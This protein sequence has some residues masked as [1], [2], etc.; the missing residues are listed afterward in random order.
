VRSTAS[1]ISRSGGATGTAACENGG[2]DARA[3]DD[4]RSLAARDAALEA[5]AARLRELDTDTADIRL[6][7]EAIDRFFAGYPAEEAA[8]REALQAAQGELAR[9]QDEL[10]DAEEAQARA[11]DDDARAHAGHAVARARDHIAVAEASLARALE[12]RAALEREAAALPETV[13]G[14]EASAAAIAGEAGVPGPGAGPR[15]LVGWASHA[16]AGLFVAL[17]QLDLQRERVIREANE[18]ASMLTG[19]ATHGSTAAQALARA[20]SY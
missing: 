10:R 8:H 18:L 17:G 16:H 15:A 19:E 2:V 5:Q 12:A 14:L 4:L 20:E 13:P 9:R 3:L 6:A 7:A 11:E 1:A